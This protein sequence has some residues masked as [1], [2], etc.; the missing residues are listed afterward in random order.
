MME[1]NIEWK[2]FTNSEKNNMIIKFVDSELK[3]NEEYFKNEIITDLVY[4]KNKVFLITLKKDK[5]LF[6]QL[7]NNN[8]II[9][10]NNIYQIENI[11]RNDNGLIY[12]TKQRK[13]TDY[14]YNIKKDYQL[15]EKKSKTR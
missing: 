4:A 11:N 6:K 14:N 9:K 3:K 5:K 15:Y 13:L 2:K 10:D 7:E 1:A 8:I 12:Y